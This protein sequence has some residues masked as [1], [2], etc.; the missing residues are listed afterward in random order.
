MNNL[1]QNSALHVNIQ[2][3]TFISTSNILVH[4]TTRHNWFDNRMHRVKASQLRVSR[5]AHASR[6]HAHTHALRVREALSLQLAESR[7]SHD[8]LQLPFAGLLQTSWSPAAPP[9]Y[10]RRSGQFSAIFLVSVTGFF[11]TV[12]MWLGCNAV[13]TK[14]RSS[15][16]WF[17][18]RRV[19]NI[20]YRF[21]VDD[22]LSRSS[23]ESGIDDTFWPFFRYFDS[24]TVNWSA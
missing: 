15:L 18:L 17:F 2:Y 23:I 19:V 1:Q 20:E 21:N 10:S 14:T 22:I 4:D 16:R 3:N 8:C 12:S 13:Q 9:F 11:G 24:D 6:R 7:F 5:T